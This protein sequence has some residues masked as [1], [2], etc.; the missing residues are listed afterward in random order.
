MNGSP[1]SAM[2][3]RARSFA[4]ELPSYDIQIWFRNPRKVTAIFEFFSQLLRFQPEAVYVFDMSFSGVIAAFLYRVLR[5]VR[6]VIDTGDVIGFLARSSGKRSWLGCGLTKA[7]EATSIQLADA[8]VVRGHFHKE[9]LKQRRKRIVAIPDGVD[10]EQFRPQPSIQ[11][12]SEL[13]LQGCV[14]VGVLGSITWNPRLNVCY[15]WELIR[16]LAELRDLAVKGLVIGD[17]DGL[18]RLKAMAVHFGVSDRLVFVGWKPYDQLPEYLNLMDIC[19]STQTNDLVG[20]VRTT[21]KLPLYLASGKHVLATAVGEA[22]RVLP[23]SMLIRYE[24]TM[25]ENYPAKLAERL[26]EIIMRNEWQA[27]RIESCRLAQTFDYAVLARSV[28]SVLSYE[29][30]R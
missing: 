5:H 11:L 23:P 12:R 25:D 7:L 22:A 21:G 3:V 30:A 2:G 9:Y 29:G 6:V 20:Q 4:R 19:L 18:D 15:G 26:R 28:E 1:Q 24:G 10:V 27:S 13:A 17:G 16:A 8:L 14:V